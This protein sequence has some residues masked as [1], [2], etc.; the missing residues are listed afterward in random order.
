MTS[1]SDRRRRVRVPVQ[2]A[3][4]HSK[5]QVLGTPVFEENS[6]I[7]LSSNG[8]SFD[9]A[10]EYK[11]GTLVL[12]EVVIEQQLLKLLVCVAWLKKS[13]EAADKFQVGAELIAIDPEHKKQMQGHLSSLI[14]KFSAKT[15]V[16]K[17]KTKKKPAKK[18]APS[19]KKSAKKPSKKKTTTKKKPT[20]KK[21]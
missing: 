9:T 7:D 21:K 3:I 4:R 20:K 13:K 2:Q 16:A 6:A 17:K 18:K 10:Q 8:I 11:K 5:Y 15:K 12:L 1:S 19:K 14:Q